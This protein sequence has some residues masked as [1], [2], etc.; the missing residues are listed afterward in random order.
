M[1]YIWWELW[2][3]K[4]CEK[5]LESSNKQYQ[6]YDR[7]TWNICVMF[8]ELI[9]SLRGQTKL[10]IYLNTNESFSK[11]WKV[12]VYMAHATSKEKDMEKYIDDRDVCNTGALLL[13]DWTFG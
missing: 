6:Y 9:L 7:I 8:P 2:N 4:H 5:V 13:I 3:K 12:L 11:F 1:L 10:G